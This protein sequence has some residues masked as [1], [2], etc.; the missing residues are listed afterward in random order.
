MEPGQIRMRL[1][2]LKV[3]SLKNKIIFLSL[4]VVWTFVFVSW[5]Y[6]GYV[7]DKEHAMIAD[8]SE[9]ANANDI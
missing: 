1:C 8:M 9:Q 6:S 2:M 5:V 4:S 3:L 7:W